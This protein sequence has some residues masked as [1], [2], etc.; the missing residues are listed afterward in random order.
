M[1]IRYPGAGEGWTPWG[2]ELWWPG[3]PGAS[4]LV[5]PCTSHLGAPTHSSRPHPP[6]TSLQGHWKK[7][8]HRKR[9]LSLIKNRPNDIDRRK[10]VGGIKAYFLNRKAWKFRVTRQKLYTLYLDYLQTLEIANMDLT[11]L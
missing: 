2:L 10:I 1:R 7:I 9:Y 6:A 11:K 8:F 5:N 3:P 4:H